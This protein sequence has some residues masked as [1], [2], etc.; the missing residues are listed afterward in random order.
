MIAEIVGTSYWRRL[1]KMFF[2]VKKCALLEGTIETFKGH[3]KGLAH[4]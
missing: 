1:N 2:Q 4:K 3:S